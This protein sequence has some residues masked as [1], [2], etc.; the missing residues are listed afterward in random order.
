MQSKL[1]GPSIQ[2][3]QFK[4]KEKR[5]KIS[6]QEHKFP[7]N[8]CLSKGGLHRYQAPGLTKKKKKQ[9]ENKSTSGKQ[10]RALEF[11]HQTMKNEKGPQ[12]EHQALEN[13]SYRKIPPPLHR[14]GGQ[15]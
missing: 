12:Q 3:I 9:R 15:N 4:K 7:K 2:V 6:Q 13:S 8:E 5:I 11:R 1:L 10:R 14:L